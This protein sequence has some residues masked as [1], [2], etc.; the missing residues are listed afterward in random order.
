MEKAVNLIQ[1]LSGVIAEQV[2]EEVFVKDHGLTVAEVQQEVQKHFY[3]TLRLQ[4]NDMVPKLISEW[5]KNHSNLI[6]PVPGGSICIQLDCDNVTCHAQAIEA[7][8]RHRLLVELISE[9]IDL[10]GEVVIDF[11]AE[12]HKDGMEASIPVVGRVSHES[13]GKGSI[14]C[15][16]LRHGEQQYLRLDAQTWERAV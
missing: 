6:V 4:G 10:R 12:E 5:N 7:A 11:D 2:C 9:E 1:A 16:F 3:S 14:I 8:E 13:G 15:L